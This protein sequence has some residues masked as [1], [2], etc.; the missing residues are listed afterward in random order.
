MI[1]QKWNAVD[2]WAPWNETASAAILRHHMTDVEAA[3]V[4]ARRVFDL[5]SIQLLALG[6]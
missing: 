3:R 6:S 1:A 5:D 4:L 2:P